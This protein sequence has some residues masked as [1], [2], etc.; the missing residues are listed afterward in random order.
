MTSSVARAE[1][2][3]LMQEGAAI[4]GAT[5]LVEGTTS[6]MTLM[7]ATLTPLNRTLTMTA[8]LP[9]ERKGTTQGIVGAI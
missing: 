1:D 3:H 4:D 9:V 7:M 6:A 2:A 8:V 5:H